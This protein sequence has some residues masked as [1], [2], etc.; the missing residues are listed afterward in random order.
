[1][2][3]Q[4][5]YRDPTP[6]NFPDDYDDSKV[7]S[8][9]KI[10]SKSIAHKDFGVHVR[11]ALMQGIE[12]GSV[13]A[14]EAKKAAVDSK[15]VADNLTERWED[16]INGQVEPEEVVDARR[17]SGKDAYPTLGKRL[18]EEHNSNLIDED[19]V[20]GSY[21]K[22]FFETEIARVKV[23][24]K[25]GLFT[26]G[27][28]TDNHWE[29]ADRDKPYGS[30]SL[31]HVKNLLAFSD[32]AD[33]LMLN[34]DNINL[35]NVDL[36]VG[37]HETETL[38]SVFLDELVDGYAD[39]FIQLGNHD[40]G[41][42]RRRFQAKS[43]LAQDEYLHDD[44]FKEVYRTDEGQGEVRNNGSLYFYKDYQDAK[45][46]LISLNTLD[47]LEGELDASSSQ[48]W[49][50]WGTLTIRQEQ[51]NWFA[52]VALMNIPT[53]YQIIVTSHCPLDATYLYPNDAA[54]YWNLDIVAGVLSAAHNGTSY[55]GTSTGGNY[56]VAI[57]VD[58]TGQGSRAV[59]GNFGGHFH[60]EWIHD[61][62][63]LKIVEVNRS[64]VDDAKKS[65]IGTAQE[66][67]FDV[68]Q[69]DT[70]NRHVYIYGFGGSTDRGYD[71]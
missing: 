37:K 30:Y 48:K 66:D 20:S 25:P 42:T 2:A 60:T 52:N 28:M 18:D 14:N 13:V 34:G 15:E 51:L 3:N 62:L 57:S 17:P 53:D 9:V 56:P 19:L 40:D 38:V 71:Y 12:I 70:A 58:Y 21:V 1:M 44:Y 7:D 32:N 24:L 55:T 45:I 11:E 64:L 63:G 16:Q 47:I 46:R 39:R 26:M 5:D 50:R 67:M 10:R 43:F 41:S 54:R 35:D 31:N 8:R 22:P 49:D 68:I 4:V 33:L 27:F 59:I 29:T 6:N 61:Y 69:V 36:N 23:E 65:D